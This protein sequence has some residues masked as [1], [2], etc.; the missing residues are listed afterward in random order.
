M[1]FLIWTRNSCD[2]IDFYAPTLGWS[3]RVSRPSCRMLRQVSSWLLPPKGDLPTTISYLSHVYPRLAKCGLCKV[4]PQPKIFSG[5]WIASSSLTQPKE[6]KKST[7]E[8]HWTRVTRGYCVSWG[9]ATHPSP[10]CPDFHCD[11]LHGSFL[12]PGSLAYH[13]R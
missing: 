1:K 10:T 13:R 5:K 6:A 12:V 9:A 8:H 3:Q 4:S 7:I 2:F 11:L